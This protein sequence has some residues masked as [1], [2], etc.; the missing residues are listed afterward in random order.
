MADIDALKENVRE[1][2]WSYLDDVRFVMLGS[3]EA[4]QHMQPMAPQVDGETETIW[5]YTGRDSDLVKAVN[6]N[7]RSMVHMCVTENDYQ[8]CLRG[9]VTEYRN[10]DKI[11]QHWSSIVA[12]WFPKGKDDPNLTMLCFT[13]ADAAIW[14]S[15]KNPITFAYEIGKA[16]L[17]DQTPDIGARGSIDFSRK[18]S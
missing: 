2:L 13:P 1:Q 15:D 3:P 6:D 8:A 10:R 16:N 9:Y 17:T 18:E 11:D 14:A 12:A 7:P 4:S 5:F